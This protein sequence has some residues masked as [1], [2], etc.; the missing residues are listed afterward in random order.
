L[1]L[2]QQNKPNSSLSIQSTIRNSRSNHHH[3]HPTR[4]YH[5]IIIIMNNKNNKENTMRTAVRYEARVCD[6]AGNMRSFSIPLDNNLDEQAIAMLHDDLNKSNMTSPGA[7]Y[8]MNAALQVARGNVFGCGVDWRC[9]MCGETARSSV[10]NPVLRSS[11]NSLVIA[12][13]LFVPICNKIGCK[14]AA[15]KEVDEE[16]SF[17]SPRMVFH[18]GAV[19]APSNLDAP[20]LWS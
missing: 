19:K 11:G 7:N 1:N 5:T 18:E 10:N 2:L 15:Q 12:D 6:G 9:T 13:R 14:R 20:P 16:V 4:T 17:D 8:A 3:H